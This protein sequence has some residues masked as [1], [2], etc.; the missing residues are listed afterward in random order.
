MHFDLAYAWTTF[1][2]AERC[3]IRPVVPTPLYGTIA[4]SQA[5]M[6]DDSGRDLVEQNT[7]GIEFLLDHLLTQTLLGDFVS[8][9]FIAGLAC[10]GRYG[11]LCQ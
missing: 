10:A 9:I 11:L 7:H 8:R 5:L 4:D 2:A 1:M 6:P 3:F